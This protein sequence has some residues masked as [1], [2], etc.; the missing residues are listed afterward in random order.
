M[1]GVGWGDFLFLPTHNFFR[2]SFLLGDIPRYFLLLYF[3]LLLANHFRS[4]L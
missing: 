4:Q 1:G 3:V 2:Q